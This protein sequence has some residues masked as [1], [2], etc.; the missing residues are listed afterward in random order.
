MHN[1]ENSPPSAASN[2]HPG[3]PPGARQ[4][5]D[6]KRP[7]VYQRTLVRGVVIKGPFGPYEQKPRKTD[8]GRTYT[9][10]DQWMIVV[11]IDCDVKGRHEDKIYVEEG[12][13]LLAAG[14]DL[15]GRA[16]FLMR[17]W[18]KKKSNKETR[19]KGAYAY[20]LLMQAPGNMPAIDVATAPALK[21]MRW[22]LK[23]NGKPSPL[24]VWMDAMVSDGRMPEDKREEFEANFRKV[25]GVVT[26]HYFALQ[27]L[28][29]ST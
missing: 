20:R 9:P 5:A 27:V 24:S 25:H 10:P 1:T 8:S 6:P 15:I 17:E 18:S 26:K 23:E 14:N 22:A 16:L 11:D 7:I 28:S 21:F 2:A 3:K 13:A 19:Q 29:L 12:H 4:G